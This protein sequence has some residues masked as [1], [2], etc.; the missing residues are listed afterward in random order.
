MFLISCNLIGFVCAGP[1]AAGVPWDSNN[2]EEYVHHPAQAVPGPVKGIAMLAPMAAVSGNRPL[3]VLL[4]ESTDTPPLASHDAAYFENLFFGPT[5]SVADYYSEV[6]YGAFTYMEAAVLDPGNDNAAPE[7]FKDPTYSTADIAGDVSKQYA[8]VKWAIQQ[9]DA[10]INFASY[11]SDNDGTVTNEEL[12]IYIVVTGQ[13]GDSGG[14]AAW[15]YHRHAGSV[16]CDG[17]TI[18]GEYSI[19]SEMNPVGTFAHE[20][21]HDLGLPDLYDTTPS[22]NP[23]S[24]GIGH[25][26]LMGSGSWCGPTHMTAWE[27]MQLGWIVPTVVPANGF[28]DIQDSETHADAYI[29][30]SASHSADEYFLVENRWR[31]TSYDSIVGRE[32][33]LN[34]E[35][36]IIYHIDDTQANNGDEAHKKVDVECADKPT[37]HVIDADDL[38]LVITNWLTDMYRRGDANDLWDCNEYDF[39]DTSTPAKAI[40]YGGGASGL[41]VSLFPCVGATMRTYLAITPNLP[42]VADANGPY[43]GV[44]GTAI[45]F[46]GTGS[47]DPDGDPLEYS[48]D[49]GDGSPV[50]TDTATPAHTY[51]DNDIYTVTLTVTDPFGLS[52][53]DTTTATVDNAA[54]TVTKGDLA[55]PNPE[56]ILP[57]VHTLPFQA[58]FSDP[59]WCDTHT[60]LWD[61]GDG[62]DAGTLT[63]EN[64]EPYATG[65]VTAT[66]AFSAP[67]DYSVTVTVTDDDNGETT[68]E[69]WT[70]HVADAAEAKHILAAYIQSLPADAFKG[71]AVQR[72]AAFTNKFSA[73]DTMIADE[74]W[75]GFIVSLES[76]IRAK[77]DGQI[78]GKPGDDWIRSIVAQ[79]HICMKIDDIVAYVKTFM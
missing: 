74:E 8:M 71:K 75:N 9:A 3:L 49:F 76:D 27:K 57:M 28:Y 18:E 64:L 21:G 22:N 68:S 54:P 12:T 78:D 10:D 62:T 73:L 69:A 14:T 59:G 13:G 52:A 77:A 31:G 36:I 25:Y 63:E 50:V 17:K 55:Q 29:L 46:D 2:D 11:D 67:G 66:H 72:K 39:T 79:Q 19:T 45:N 60:A 56:F 35:G 4:V 44:E 15:A 6:S 38:D 48:W 20:L 42:P 32:G 41:S 5:P 37:S 16:T 58:T 34:D 61:F 33:R 40:W 47:S 26:G 51:C 23:D 7:W 30:R 65:T 24:E 53:T 1:P 70:V 43:V